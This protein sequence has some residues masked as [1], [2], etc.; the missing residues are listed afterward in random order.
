MH[1]KKQVNLNNIELDAVIEYSKSILNDSHKQEL[2]RIKS[3]IDK[4]KQ[5][6]SSTNINFESSF[7]P[8]DEWNRMASACEELNRK[9]SM[10]F[11]NDLRK[12]VTI[13]TQK[14]VDNQLQNKDYDFSNTVFECD[15]VFSN[16]TLTDNIT[17]AGSV[18]KGNVTFRN[19][20]FNENIDCFGSVF[21]Q[22]LE[23]QDVTFNSFANF[24]QA[25]F[26]DTSFSTVRFQAEARFTEARFLS[27]VHF[28]MV[29]WLGKVTFTKASFQR[30]VRYSNNTFHKQVEFY[31]T[32]FKGCTDFA[33]VEFMNNVIFMSTKFLDEIWFIRAKFCKSAHFKST[34]FGESGENNRTYF[35]EVEFKFGVDFESSKFNQKVVFR[36]II[37][38]EH[39]FF[40]NVVFDSVFFYDTKFLEGA[41]FSRT[42]FSEVTQFKDCSFYKIISFEQSRFSGITVFA[43]PVVRNQQA[44]ATFN[45]GGAVFL[46]NFSYTG[47]DYPT[48]ANRETARIFKHQLQSSGNNIEAL[49]FY[50]EEMEL[51]RKELQKSNGRWPEK[52]QLWFLRISSN[53]GLSWVRG[54]AFIVCWVLTT[55]GLFILCNSE[56][57]K[58]LT[59]GYSLNSWIKLAIDGALKVFNITHWNNI[60]E[61][62][63]ITG[64]GHLALFSGRIFI[65]L[66]IYQTIQALRKFSRTL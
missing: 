61:G 54:I 51:Y 55:L 44:L 9:Y 49:H 11:P 39:P 48:S 36:D 38:A 22:K 15:I 58:T 24:R 19:T 6:A 13:T 26:L 23:F 40:C 43:N 66:G 60:I 7:S 57:V 30:E 3:Q 1:N 33:N 37:F 53:Y 59:K 2:E 35:K 42:E 28:S 27:N 41:D 12:K 52:I 14:E 46:S 18:F 50:K 25:S 64:W 16:I 8:I 65:S 32:I 21:F 31:S 20:T 5:I 34:H 4:L 47:N 29:S 17:F 56:G 63:P 10:F 62:V 45:L